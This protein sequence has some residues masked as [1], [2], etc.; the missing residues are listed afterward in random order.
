MAPTVRHGK[1]GA[2]STVN[3]ELKRLKTPRVFSPKFK[4]S[5]ELRWSPRRKSLSQMRALAGFGEVATASSIAA[6]VTRSSARPSA[7]G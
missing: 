4:A 2:S 6:Q 5:K 3:G 1:P 7:H